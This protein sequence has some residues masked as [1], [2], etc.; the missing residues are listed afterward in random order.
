MHVNVNRVTLKDTL[1]FDPILFMLYAN[2]TQLL[3]IW[4]FIIV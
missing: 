4:I 1:D 2:L 3:P